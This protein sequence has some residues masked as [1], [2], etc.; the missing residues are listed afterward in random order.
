MVAR[1][2]SASSCHCLLYEVV[3]SDLHE[4]I[5]T[6]RAKLPSEVYLAIE[7]VMRERAE[8]IEDDFKLKAKA[9]DFPSPMSDAQRQK[10]KCGLDKLK[11]RRKT[12]LAALEMRKKQIMGADYAKFIM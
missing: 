10:R 7:A 5:L 4:I 8:R 2:F 12:N 6:L 11:A 9:F 1:A 3:V